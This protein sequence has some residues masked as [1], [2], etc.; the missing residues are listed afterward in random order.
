MKRLFN[1][2]DMD[3]SGKLDYDEFLSALHVEIKGNDGSLLSDSWKTAI[4]QQVCVCVCVCVLVRV[5]FVEL[6]PVSARCWV[7]SVCGADHQ[8][9]VQLQLGA[10]GAFRAEGSHSKVCLFFR[11]TRFA[12][13]F[14]LSRSSAVG[15]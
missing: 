5:V 2:I 15:L 7:V 1:A 6:M 12:P 4:V 11:V 14:E 3:G 10:A 13:L 9:A 8:R